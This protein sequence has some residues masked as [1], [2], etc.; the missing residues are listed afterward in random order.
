GVGGFGITYLAFDTKL[1]RRVALKEYMP[2]ALVAARDPA[3]WQP[4]FRKPGDRAGYRRFLD[5][6]RDQ[7]LPI[8]RFNHPNSVPIHRV[9]VQ[10]E[11]AYIVME[12]L[13]EVSF[14]R[15]VASGKRLAEAELAHLLAGMLDGLSAMH[16][17]KLLHRDVKPSNI[18][19]RGDGTPV[20]ID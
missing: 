1:E 9:I 8:A 5:R 20:L 16:A 12:H 2:E 13:G 3:T 11:T 4:I 7:A 10:D 18:M 6:F 14:G 17:G 15:L 19:L